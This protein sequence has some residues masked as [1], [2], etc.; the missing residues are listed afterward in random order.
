MFGLLTR[1]DLERALREHEKKLDMEWT[2]WYDKFRILYARI[3]K[4]ARALEGVDEEVP[5]DGALG[6]SH[7]RAP[8]AAPGGYADRLAAARRRFGG[9]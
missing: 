5:T 6:P 3:S 2:A 8:A 9:G 1:S 7:D 4:R